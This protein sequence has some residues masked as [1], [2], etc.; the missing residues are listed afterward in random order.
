M[1]AS[2][3]TPDRPDDQ[4]AALI[5][6][7]LDRVLASDAFRSAPQLAAFLGFIVERSLAGRAA[8]LKGYTIA[9]EAFGRSPDFDPQ[10]DPIVRVEAGRLRKALVQYYAGEGAAEPLRITIPVGGYVPSFLSDGPGLVADAE[11]QAPTPADPAADKFMAPPPPDEPVGQPHGAADRVESGRA[12]LAIVGLVLIIVIMA[13]AVAST[14]IGH[15][16]EAGSPPAGVAQ[17]N[18]TAPPPAAARPPV[19]AAQQPVHLPVVTVTVAAPTDDPALA[20]VMQRFARLLVDVMARFDDLI[21][22]KA[23][24]PGASGV[25]A[26]AYVFEINASRVGADTEGFGRLRSVRD[27]R[28]VWTTSTTRTLGGGPDDPELLELARRLA[29]RLAEPFGI[30]HADFRQSATSPAMRCMFQA[31][32]FRRTMQPA[33]HLAARACLEG[34]LAKDAGFH[35]AWSQLALLILDEY[36]QGL[37]PQ[38]GPPLD[39]AL[40]AALTAVR[41]APSSARAQQVMMDV[42]FAR[43]ALEDAIKSGREALAR[44]PYDPDIMAD[45]GSRFVRLNRPAEGLPLLARAV[46]L[47]A[48][49]PPWY[50]FYAFLAA[51]LLGAD[52]L[53]E[54]YGTALLADQG[55][56]SLLGRSLAAAKAKDEVELATCL[57]ALVEAAPLFA[58]DPRLYLS[59]KGFAPEL[60]DRVLAGL[61]P[62]AL[63][64]LTRR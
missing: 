24:Q 35:P 36:T 21:S 43:G 5:R 14:R 64:V 31:F 46:E 44:N 28:I 60:I 17:Q 7:A 29:I 32:D 18:R 56:L 26:G 45:L 37:N 48:G 2:G 42:L 58:I 59:Q 19:D 23:L 57:R 6:A 27:G 12:R 49:R 39:R 8:E 41:L 22:V 52:K 13:V 53:A 55:A 40:S 20:E 16:R 61:G 33:E 47:S 50:D 30:I 1:V 4:T 38:P 54:S 3:E 34:V 63:G 11:D 15:R 10:T 9:V 62:N 51:H 25:E